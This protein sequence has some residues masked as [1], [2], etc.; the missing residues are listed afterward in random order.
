MKRMN[1]I[2]RCMIAALA[3]MMAIGMGTAQAAKDFSGTVNINTASPEQ[4]TE[5]PGIG[6]SKARA[7]V[8]YRMDK[9]FKTVD[10]IKEVKGVGD[11]LYAKISP[12]LTVEGQTRLGVD[13][14][15]PGSGAKTKK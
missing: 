10:E 3:V 2:G 11:K 9:P 5:L 8:A 7:I 13:Y 14:P 15:K 1:R 12:H 4:L 6:P